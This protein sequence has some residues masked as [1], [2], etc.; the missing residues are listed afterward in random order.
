MFARRKTVR[1]QVDANIPWSV[2]QDPETG[3]WIGVC[4]ALN[5]NAVGDTWI[6]FQQ[7][8]NEA[9]QT[10]FL[11]LFEDGELDAYLRRNGWTTRGGALPPPT[12]KPAFDVP[13]DVRRA[14]IRD[15]VAVG[16]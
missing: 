8:A 16:S 10:L 7:S 13:F 4:D 5:L 15:L 6:D 1:V 12:V 11:D 3:T 9:I 14:S 2:A